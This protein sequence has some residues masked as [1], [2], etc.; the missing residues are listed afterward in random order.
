MFKHLKFKSN[1]AR[2]TSTGELPLLVP[3]HRSYQ[4]SQG[5]QGR[6]DS[7]GMA[8]SIHL[9]ELAAVAMVTMA[10]Q[11]RAGAYSMATAVHAV[12]GSQ[13]LLHGRNNSDRL[14]HAIPSFNTT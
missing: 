7:G 2:V 13:V 6:Y 10:G 14:I 9:A 1:A 8:S 12:T 11:V 4:S 5:A 3:D